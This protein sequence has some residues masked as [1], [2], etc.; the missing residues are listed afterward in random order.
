M[1]PAGTIKI[2]ANF[3]GPNGA[4]PFSPVIQGNDGV[5]YGTTTAGGSADGGVVFRINTTGR[6]C[7]LLRQFD[8]TD[9][10]DGLTPF[11][12]LVAAN[13]GK[14]YGTTFSG[15]NEPGA[16][17]TIFQ[18]DTKGDYSVVYN[19]DIAHGGGTDGNVHA[20]YEWNDLWYRRKRR[21]FRF[22][23]RP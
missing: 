1:S 16:S 14:F 6:K 8:L 10:L 23:R 3:I 12:G 22:G 9:P 20:T 19:F 15:G 21:R 11:A 4:T 17:G 18:I 13:D 2:I 5:L 7:T